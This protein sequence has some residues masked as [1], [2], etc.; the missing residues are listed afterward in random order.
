MKKI[1]LLL[2]IFIIWIFSFSFTTNA[3]E[4][5]VTEKIPWANCKK[6]WT[7]EYTCDVKKWFWTVTEMMWEI[8]KFFTLIAALGWVLMIVIF[9]IQYSMWWMDSWVKESAKKHITQTIMWLVVLLL[10]WVILNA[11]APWIYK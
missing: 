6:I 1:I 7:N 11:I 4:V 9:G 3:I 10:S 8:I 5:K 2:S